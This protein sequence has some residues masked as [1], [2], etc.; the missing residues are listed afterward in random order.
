[1]KNVKIFWVPCPENFMRDSEDISSKYGGKLK[2]LYVIDEKHS[3]VNFGK[4]R[5]FYTV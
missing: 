1:M 3:E 5:G 2:I 4:T